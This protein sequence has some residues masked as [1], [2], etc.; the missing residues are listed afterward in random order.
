ME[1]FQAVIHIIARRV[2]GSIPYRFQARGTSEAMA[3]QEVARMAMSRLRY[4]LTKL[5]Q[6]PYD[7]FSMQAHGAEVTLLSGFNTRK[8]PK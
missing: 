3:L 6:P 1:D 5:S 2:T 8:I 7:H 4:D